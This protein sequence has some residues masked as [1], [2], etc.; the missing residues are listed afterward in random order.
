MNYFFQ[1]NVNF[2]K[3]CSEMKQISLHS[4]PYLYIVYTVTVLWKFY[5]SGYPTKVNA[6]SLKEEKFEFLS[7]QSSYP[8]FENFRIPYDF[9]RNF[10]QF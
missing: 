2:L 8:Y 5:L 9:K 1:I 7:L 4:E 10:V 6:P 3:T